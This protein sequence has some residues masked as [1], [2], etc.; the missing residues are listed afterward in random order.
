MR[1]GLG[2]R[3]Q[4][5][6]S[7]QGKCHDEDHNLRQQQ[8]GPEAEMARCATADTCLGS[9]GLLVKITNDVLMRLLRLHVSANGLSWASVHA[10]RRCL[11]RAGSFFGSATSSQGALLPTNPQALDSS[12]CRFYRKFVSC[13]IGFKTTGSGPRYRLGR[14]VRPLF[15]WELASITIPK[16][17]AGENSY[18]HPNDS[19]NSSIWI[20]IARNA[21]KLPDAVPTSE[22]SGVRLSGPI[23]LYVKQ[24]PSHEAAATACSHPLHESLRG[25]VLAVW[26]IRLLQISCPLVWS[27]QS[28]LG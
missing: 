24:H 28:G 14:P 4:A 19:R 23:F 27:P 3:F 17:H 8:Q 9:W 5:V 11:W 13:F 12:L 16:I 2:S 26:N 6:V 22:V 20:R 10:G 15:T 1:Q 25:L 18:S 7:D 21:G